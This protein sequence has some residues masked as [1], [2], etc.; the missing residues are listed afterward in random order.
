LRHIAEY[1]FCESAL[2]AI[3]IP[4][5]VEILDG[6]ASIVASHFYRL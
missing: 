6:T 2:T 1:A 4:S 5:S 3:N